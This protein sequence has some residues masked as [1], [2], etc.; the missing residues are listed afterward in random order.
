MYLKSEMA[1]A[2]LELK[3]QMVFQYIGLRPMLLLLSLWDF[4]LIKDYCEQRKYFF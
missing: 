2:P 1:F 3:M 4:L